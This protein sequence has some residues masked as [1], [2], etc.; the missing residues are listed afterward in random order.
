MPPLP[1]V[2]PLTA[3]VDRSI[4]TTRGNGPQWSP[5]RFAP[6]VLDSW[7]VRKAPGKLVGL[8]RE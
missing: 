5:E 2:P 6:I 4:A 1:E 7:I 3:E 8:Q